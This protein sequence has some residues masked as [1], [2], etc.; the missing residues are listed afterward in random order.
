MVRRSSNLKLDLR[1]AKDL[2]PGQRAALKCIG[3]P[4]GSWWGPANFRIRSG[5]VLYLG[6]FVKHLVP[7][8]LI[9]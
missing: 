6:T 1:T 3:T 5:F 2:H 9:F 8:A 4:W 7:F